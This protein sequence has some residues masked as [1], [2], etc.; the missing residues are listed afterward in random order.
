[1]DQ[2][3]PPNGEVNENTEKTSTMAIGM[4]STGQ[5]VCNGVSCLCVIAWWARQSQYERA[6]AQEQTVGVN[7]RKI[8][9]Q[10]QQQQ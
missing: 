10:Q 1:M 5:N 7:E 8:W 9:Q 4:I 6:G 3:S 2:S